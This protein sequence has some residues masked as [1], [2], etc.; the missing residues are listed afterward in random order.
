MDNGVPGI[1]EIRNG[2]QQRKLCIIHGYM[3]W[4]EVASESG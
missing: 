1:Y 2:Q 4:T 3:V